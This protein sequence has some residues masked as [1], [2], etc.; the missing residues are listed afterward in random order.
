V[1]TR[2]LGVTWG[3]A[4]GATAIGSFVAPALLS[5]IGLRPAL[6]VVGAILPSLI[7]ISYR[8]LLPLDADAAPASQL[9]LVERVALFAP[10]SLVAKERIASH[11]IPIE[12]AAGEV[13]IR[14]GE[15]GGRFYVID[16]GRF[17]IDA[18]SQRIQMGAGGFFGEIALL[19]DVPRTATVRADTDAR[20]YALE[21]EDFLAVITGNPLA[22]ASAHAVAEARLEANAAA[23]ERGG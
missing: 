10:L 3:L 4:M 14:L 21:H 2:V 11:L 5:L 18:V 7:A 23:A 15:S 6:L 13:V 16:E 19:H 1:L 9:G 17:T 12:V 22:S 20:L 8:Q